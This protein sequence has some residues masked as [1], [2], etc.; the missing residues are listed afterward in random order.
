MLPDTAESLRSAM[1]KNP[2]MKVLV[3]QGYYDLATPSFATEYMVSHM[4]LDTE[5]RDNLSIRYYHAGHMFYLD[6]DS[7]AAFRADVV[8][9]F[10]E[11]LAGKENP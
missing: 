10:S 1:S 3:A 6:T 2:F 8:E 7:L 9:F 5:V 11:S 4:N